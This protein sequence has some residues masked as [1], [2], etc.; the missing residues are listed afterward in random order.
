MVLIMIM[1]A[2]IL[3]PNISKADT[4]IGGLENVATTAEDLPTGNVDIGEA[5]GSIIQFFLGFLGIL[6]VI[7]FLYAGFLY[8]T[9]G[10]EEAKITKAKAYMKNAVIG[11]VIIMASYIIVYFVI[12]EIQSELLN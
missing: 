2:V 6:A 4:I 8:M 10:G 1:S 5:V 12:T 3:I 11:I 9:A 7:L